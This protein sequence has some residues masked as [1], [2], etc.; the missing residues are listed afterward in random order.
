MRLNGKIGYQ[1][2]LDA[3]TL[4]GIESSVGGKGGQKERKGVGGRGAGRIVSGQKEKKGEKMRTKE[5]RST[6][7]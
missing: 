2:N 7:I 3:P 1:I 5:I 4:N 6:L